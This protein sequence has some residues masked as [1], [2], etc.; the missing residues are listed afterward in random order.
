MSTSPL[1]EALQPEDLRWTWNS[2][3]RHLCW[4]YCNLLFFTLGTAPEQLCPQSKYGKNQ[5]CSRVTH[6]L[7]EKSSSCCTY[8][9][10]LVIIWIIPFLGIKSLRGDFYRAVFAFLQDFPEI[11]NS[12]SCCTEFLKQIKWCIPLPM[13]AQKCTISYKDLPHVNLGCSRR[14]ATERSDPSLVRGKWKSL[15]DLLMA[16]LKAKEPHKILNH[17]LSPFPYHLTASTLH[18]VI[19]QEAFF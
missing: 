13:Q 12:I 1:N 11:V 5:W 17:L 2:N 7:I 16:C 15:T 9:S 3:K 8:F 14:L 10:W 6:S 4:P 18:T 19:K